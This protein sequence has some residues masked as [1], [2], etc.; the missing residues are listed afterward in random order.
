MSSNNCD[1]CDNGGII[2]IYN[3]SNASESNPSLAITGNGELLK[4]VDGINWTKAPT[5][6]G[7]AIGNDAISFIEKHKDSLSKDTKV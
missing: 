5:S 2:D 6:I 1:N 7:L 4:S 3:A